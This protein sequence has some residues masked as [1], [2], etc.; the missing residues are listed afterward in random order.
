MAKS[1]RA[2]SL[3]GVI[4]TYQKYDPVRFPGPTAEIPDVA[5]AAMEHLLAYGERRP[6]TEEE[7]ARAIRL[8]PSQIAGFGPSIDALLALLR[9]RK[10]KILRRYETDHVRRAA[11]HAFDQS[12]EGIDVPLSLQENYRRAVREGQL[13][14]LERLWYA[15][16]RQNTHAARRLLNAIQR[17]GELYQIEELAAKY[18][19]TGRTTL[20]VPLGLQV[21]EELE[22]I[23]ALIRQ[24]EEA[25]KEARIALV[26]LDALARVSRAA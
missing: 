25:R 5:S 11:R 7:L 1:S 4:H 6:L 18:H 13:H 10:E 14:D 3:G 2:N 21:R 17:L 23:D 16:E 24:L 19:F 15:I 8:D 9:E 26:D 12:S 22:Q 20:D